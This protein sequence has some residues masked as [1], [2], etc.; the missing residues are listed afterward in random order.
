MRFTVTVRWTDSPVVPGTTYTYRIVAVNPFGSSEAQEVSISVDPLIKPMEALRPEMQKVVLGDSKNIIPLS[1][2]LQNYE[3]NYNRSVLEILSVN[4][5]GGASVRIEGENALIDSSRMSY[6]LEGKTVNLEYTVH[7]AGEPLNDIFTT[8]VHM[9]LELVAPAVET[10]KEEELLE[11]VTG[12]IYDNRSDLERKMRLYEPPSPRE[13]FEKWGRISNSEYFEDGKDAESSKNT[14]GDGAD[15]A[16]KWQLHENQDE[17]YLE[18]TKNSV[19]A[20]FVSPDGEESDN[21]TLEATVSSKDDDNDTIGL[22]VAFFRD[23]KSSYILEAARSQGSSSGENFIEP[24]EGWGLI[25]RR[26]SPD[27]ENPEIGDVLWIRQLNVGGVMSR[28]WKDTRSRIKVVRSGD[29]VTITTTDWNDEN[30]YVPGSVIA[31]NL[32]SDPELSRF[33]G[34]QKFGYFTASQ[35]RTS[36]RNIVLDGGVIQDKLFYLDPD[37]GES[38]VWWY[39]QSFNRWIPMAG[40][41]IQGVLGYPLEITNPETGETFL[42]ERKGFRRGRWEDWQKL[43]DKWNRWDRGN[44]DNHNRRDIR[45]RNGEAPGN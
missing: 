13:I 7:I 27:A 15:Y 11:P 24:R 28:G 45:N 16:L 41:D 39:D 18:Y 19:Y 10:I 38:E 14:N 36:F 29:K 22:I 5:D 25:V 6:E 2:L 3:N 20:G 35:E 8:T 42:I 33:R 21:F 23:G 12:F 30:N 37:T 9:Q 4:I 26:L 1:D 34:P 32:R 31:V 43:W 44:L 40:A 17:T